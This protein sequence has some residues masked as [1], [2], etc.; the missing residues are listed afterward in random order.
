[1]ANLYERR[2]P[3]GGG[4]LI[5]IVLGL[6]LWASFAALARA[7]DP[8]TKQSFL[9]YVDTAGIAPVGPP[10]IYIT[11]VFAKESPNALPSS[12]VLVAWDCLTRPRMVKRL[13][14]VVPVDFRLRWR[15]WQHH[16]SRSPVAG[17]D[18]RAHGE[19]HLRNRPDTRE[20][21]EGTESVLGCLS[22]TSSR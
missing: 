19:P 3:P 2:V 10:G 13:A 7:Q 9:V 21:A 17:S 11:W 1:V 18:R 8:A 4:I 12:G 14:Q 15:H 22:L 5:G 16:R 20:A 6:M